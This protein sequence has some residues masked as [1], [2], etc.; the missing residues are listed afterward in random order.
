MSK[1]YFKALGAGA[2]VAEVQETPRLLLTKVI[3]EEQVQLEKRVGL[4]VH[5]GEKG[6]TSY[7]RPENYTGMV[8]FLKQKGIECCFMETSVLYGGERFK[9]ELHTQ[10]ALDHGFTQAPIVI[11]DGEEGEEFVEVPIHQKH[12]EKCKIGK[13]FA[14]YQQLI[15]LAH[16]KGHRLAGFGGAIKQLSMGC[17]SK[18]GKLE[19]HLGIHPKISGWKCKRCHLCQKRCHVDAIHI[20]ERSFIDTKRCV[21]CGACYS[22]CPH[23]AI[24][25]MTLRG[26]LKALL[27]LKAFPEKLAEY[28]LAAQKGKRNIYFNFAQNITKHC[29]CESVSQK[30]IMPDIGIFASVDPVAIDA[31]CYDAAA[32]RGKKFRGYAQIVYAE[33][34]GLGTRQYELVEL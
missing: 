2:S 30:A 11:A 26:I 7:I 13:A 25:I 24:S 31:A 15:V 21:G 14:D 6:C 1:V 20:G 27:E 22:I 10:L 18:G 33:K 29:D 32:Q 19:M 28:A 23:K 3:E 4:K 12:F 17:A 34:I 9:R 5:F 8:D 16:F